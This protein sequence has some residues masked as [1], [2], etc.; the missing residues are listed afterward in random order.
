[1]TR[2]PRDN[3]NLL[4][5]LWSVLTSRQRRLVIGAQILSIVMALSTVAGI[6]S[7]TPFFSVL[8]DPELVDRAG[9]VHWL[10]IHLGLT[11]SRSFQLGL[12]SLFMTAVLI[13]NLIN[14]IGSLMMIRLSWSI[15]TE[16]QS[17]LL[18]EYLCRPYLFHAKTHSSVLF[19]N[20]IYET[21][22]V[23]NDILQNL[24][25]LVTNIITA[26]FIILSVMLLDPAVAGGM[27]SV[28]AGGYVVIYLVV[29]NRLYR[30]GQVQ[31][32]CFTEQTRIVNESLG[33]IKEILV[34]GIQSFFRRRFEDASR[35][36][37]RA[38]CHAQLAGQSPRHVM[39]C[40]AVAG[41][42]LVALFAGRQGGGIGHWLGKLTFLGFAAY[43]LLPALQQAF[44]A[45]V[46]LRID[47]AGFAVIAPDIRLARARPDRHAPTVSSL[48][49]VSS[50]DGPL[51]D[52]RLKGVSFRYQPDRPL[53]VSDVSLEIPA[54]AVVGFVGANG[55]GKT[56]LVDLL[57]GLLDPES[58]QI[59]V[60]GIA[61]DTARRKAWQTQIAYVPQNIF[62]LDTTIAE[63]IAL[64]V[65][66][67]AIDQGRLIAAARLAQLDVFV[68]SLPGGYDHRVGE[69]GMGL[70][71][72]Q[73]QRI[74]IARALY[75]KASVLILDE[76]T[77]ALDGLT[78]HELLG[79]LRK[80]RGHYTIVL[81]AHQS[82]TMRACDVI[83]QFDRG[84]VSGVGSYAD[85]LKGSE[86]FRKIV[87]VF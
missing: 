9:P 36:Y 79:T 68:A 47:R 12:G 53:A 27:I 40:V 43:R 70:S 52:I 7:I 32:R 77:N 49:G 56:T 11:D 15:S 14:V 61:L 87:N 38:D 1:L 19:N 64:G 21:T 29:R 54:R 45:I 28:L 69:R 51:S 31:S 2:V 58:G 30:S 71:G 57:A 73:R 75:T 83:F 59:E 24:F 72:G 60:D 33:A 17:L 78:E 10:C 80:L 18:G 25:M 3:M 50:A 65:S 23:T 20:I 13:A 37:A 22:R 66:R 85:L 46:R 86:S 4:S 74:G 48:P 67:P 16:L 62:L 41:L 81:V 63:N 84:K 82:S 35:A 39:E 6:A 76:A 8:G 5:D 55:S 44:A 34:L 42:V 26:T